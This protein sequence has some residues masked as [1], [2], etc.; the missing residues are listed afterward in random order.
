MRAR[1]K[2]RQWGGPFGGL[3]TAVLWLWAGQAAWGQAPAVAP[4][5]EG[6]NLGLRAGEELRP[7]RIQEIYRRILKYKTDKGVKVVATMGSM[8]T[9]GGYYIACA[10]DYVYAQPTTL[11]GNIG[12]RR[13]WTA[14]V[15][16]ALSMPLEVDRGDAEVAVAE[17]ALDDDERHALVRH[18][19]GVG[20]AELVGRERRRTLAIVAVWRSSARAAAADHV[21]LVSVP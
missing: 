13:A 3:A 8:A 2:G 7:E 4:Q 19:D 14:S 21:A 15:I 5:G 10:A 1:T 12:A 18:L 11:T 6:S 16:S 9:S 20:V 17:L